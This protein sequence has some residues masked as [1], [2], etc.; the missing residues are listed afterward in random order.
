MSILLNSYFPSVGDLSAEKLAESRNLLEGVVRVKYPDQDTRPGSVFGD[1]HLNPA[2]VTAASCSEAVTRLVSD[3]TLE[4]VAGGTIYNSEVVREYLK[5]YVPSAGSSLMS[6]GVVRLVFSGDLVELFGEDGFYEF[7]AGMYF[8]LGDT[9]TFVPRAFDEGSLKIYPVGSYLGGFDGS[10]SYAL[11][12][13]SATR[14]FV[15]IPLI[16]ES[17]GAVLEGAALLP[18]V[19]IPALESIT[20]LGDFFVPA[21][22]TESLRSQARRALIGFNAVS[23]N[24]RQGVLRAVNEEFPDITYASAVMTGDAE[25]VR[26]V[27]GLVDLPSCDVYIRTPLY[28]S[29]VREVIALQYDPEEGV[30]YGAFSPS[31][32]PLRINSLRVAA[33]ATG[34]DLQFTSY[35]IPK[36]ENLTG[37]TSAFGVR[38]GY[39]LKTPMLFS[40][41]GD[42]LIPFNSVGGNLI[43]YFEVTYLA[44]LGFAAVRSFL[45]SDGNKPVGIDTYVRTAVPVFVNDIEV[46]YKPEPGRILDTAQLATEAA[47]HFNKATPLFPFS[48]S[49]VIESAFFAGARS[50]TELNV[51]MTN[52]SAPTSHYLPYGTEITPA[53]LDD[54]EEV[55]SYVYSD[56]YDTLW[57]APVEEEFVLGRKNKAYLVDTN[58]RYR[59]YR[60]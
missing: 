55:T 35:L 12:R 50:V 19:E 39:A 1:L 2:A 28:G 41:G 7:T 48:E 24:T 11:S 54:A 17:S 51:T 60:V 36:D 43:Q 4:N 49:Q 20:V 8:T 33:G 57:V 59:Y 42:P 52:Y 13:T 53:N 58:T 10:N 45:E 15:D 44:D 29:T 3:L 46:R 27:T 18:S 6:Y 34:S 31:H 5:N 22:I 14:Y 37:V 16:G 23:F 26:N 56:S 47:N 38:A 25:M 9:A 32:V 30:F 40:S 21:L